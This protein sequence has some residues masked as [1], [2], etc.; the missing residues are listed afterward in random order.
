MK[1]EHLCKARTI[2][3][4]GLKGFFFKITPLWCRQLNSHSFGLYCCKEMTLLSM[5]VPFYYHLPSLLPPRASLMLFAYF[6]WPQSSSERFVLWMRFVLI[7]LG[8]V[9]CPNAKILVGW[10]LTIFDGSCHGTWINLLQTLATKRRLLALLPLVVAHRWKSPKLC[11]KILTLCENWSRCE[12]MWVW[13]N[14]SRH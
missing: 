11:R 3:N 6:L 1:D 13:G 10:F 2:A 4:R 14:V 7:T 5:D 8:W 12:I 9:L